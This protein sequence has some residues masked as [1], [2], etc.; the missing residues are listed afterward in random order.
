M[1]HIE[2]KS[3][4]KR[5]FISI[6]GR[7]LVC[8]LLG[9]LVLNVS[10]GHLMMVGV[11]TNISPTTGMGLIKL[12]EMNEMKKHVLSMAMV[13]AMGLVSFNGFAAGGNSGQVTFN[14]EVVDAPCN[15]APGQDGADVKVP[16]GQLSMAQLNAG[17]ET[18]RNFQLQLEDCALAGK[19]ASI[20]FKSIQANSANTLMNTIG[21]ATGL[22]IGL[23]SP[24]GAITFGTSQ[25]LTGLNDG[26]NTLHFSAIA[27]KA[28]AATD[29][30]AGDFTAVANFEIAYQ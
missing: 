26:K 14:G 1:L 28:V 16:F 30:T 7:F 22:G 21:S 4:S 25:P 23:R 10:L 5:H 18:A 9:K 12:N 8:T 6:K 24:T 13:A 20:T 11:W 2:T 29:V 27:K 17:Q 3:H 19:T 15:L